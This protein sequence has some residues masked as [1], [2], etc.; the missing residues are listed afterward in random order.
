ME[1]NCSNQT[2][3]TRNILAYINMHQNELSQTHADN[4]VAIGITNNCV[5]N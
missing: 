4:Q 5:L 1:K 3:W 2:I